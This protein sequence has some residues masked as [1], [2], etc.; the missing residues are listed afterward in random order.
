MSNMNHNNEILIVT[1]KERWLKLHLE[2]GL[3]ITL[4]AIRSD[5][6][7]TRS[8]GGRSRTKKKECSD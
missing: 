1:E 2:G 3:S 5:F 7:E 8:T 4:L 6:P